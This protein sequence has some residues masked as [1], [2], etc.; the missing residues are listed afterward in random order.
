MGNIYNSSLEPNATENF[1]NNE[2]LQR[3]KRI[4]YCEIHSLITFQAEEQ[5]KEKFG[6]IPK[7]SNAPRDVRNFVRSYQSC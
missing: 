2:N 5:F 4:I 3:I 1:N 7:I 6:S